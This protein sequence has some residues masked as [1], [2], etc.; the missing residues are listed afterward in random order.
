MSL[1]G[2]ISERLGSYADG[3]KVSEQYSL[4]LDFSIYGRLESFGRKAANEDN[5]GNKGEWLNHF[6][7]ALDGLRARLLGVLLHYRNIH[8]WDLVALPGVSVEE[9]EMHV[10]RMTEYHLSTIL[11]HM[12]ST[13]ECMVFALNALGYAIDS[14]QFRDVTKASELRR[15]FP[16]NIIGKPPDY[17]D[18][19]LAGY[20]SYFPSLS[21]Y[22]RQNRELILMTSNQHDVSKHRSATFEGGRRRDDPPAGFFHQLGIENDRAKQICISPF[23]E[24]LLVSEPKIPW[25]QRK[26]VAYRETNKLEDVVPI[27]CEF[28]N[29]SGI[30]ALGDV[31]NTIKLNRRK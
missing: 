19:V 11:F 18:G 23:A 21:T 28:M 22:W 8:S 2:L 10:Y 14:T 17:A 24:I 27:F 25:R 20:T 7:W 29:E 5:L 16:S 13:L 3:E 4:Q 9:L 6:I 26:P 30:K 15:I 31:S 12:D 1:S